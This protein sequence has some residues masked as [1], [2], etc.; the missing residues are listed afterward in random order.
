MK[1]PVHRGLGADP[2]A[3]DLKPLSPWPQ[4]AWFFNEAAPSLHPAEQ[5]KLPKLPGQV[6]TAGA[7]RAFVLGGHRPLAGP[8]PLTEQPLPAR[9]PPF[10]QQ[11][12]LLLLQRG[13]RPRLLPDGAVQEIRGRDVT[14]RVPSPRLVEADH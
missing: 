12:R 11:L 1:K 6:P 5:A 7:Q 14:S 4:A 8:S 9:L 13:L 2:V 3:G 10:C